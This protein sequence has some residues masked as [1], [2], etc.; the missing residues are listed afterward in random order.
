[1]IGAVHRL[2]RT[3][4]DMRRGVSSRPQY[5]R[6]PQYSLHH[7]LWTMAQAQAPVP[8]EHGHGGLYIMERFKRMALPPFKGES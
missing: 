8:Q 5:P 4:R 7:H 6:V 3:S 1:M 2:G